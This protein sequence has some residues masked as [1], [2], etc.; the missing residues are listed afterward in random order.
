MGTSVLDL[1]SYQHRVKCSYYIVLETL[2]KLSDYN[3]LNFSSSRAL[4]RNIDGNKTSVTLESSKR[5]V[6]YQGAYGMCSARLGSWHG[7]VSS[8]HCKLCSKEFYLWFARVITYLYGLPA[9]L[10]FLFGNRKRRRRS[11]IRESK[12]PHKH[13]CCLSGWCSLPVWMLIFS[14][15]VVSLAGTCRGCF[16]LVSYFPGKE[17]CVFRCLPLQQCEA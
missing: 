11:H 1:Y 2:H 14:Q 12:P 4:L 16:V 6:Q 8:F 10:P 3:F 9:I 15:A 13:V 5:L 7:L 17:G